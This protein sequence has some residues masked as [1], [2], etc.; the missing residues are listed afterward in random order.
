MVTLESFEQ[1]IKNEIDARTLETPPVNENRS[2]AS[3][4]GSVVGEDSSQKELCKI[5]A[6][7]ES[8]EDRLRRKLSSANEKP[9]TAAADEICITSGASP[10][11]SKTNMKELRLITKSLESFEDQIRRKLSF[12]VKTNET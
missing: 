5:R 2:L 8:F 3:G 1:R 7:L 4:E 10:L 12:S 9:E 11:P 6:N